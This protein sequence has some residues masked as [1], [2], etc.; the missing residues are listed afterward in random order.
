MQL[1]G[2]GRL[3]RQTALV[4]ALVAGVQ[5]MRQM[6]GLSALAKAS[7]KS[8]IRLLGPILHQLMDGENPGGDK[9]TWEARRYPA[10]SVP[11]KS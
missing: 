11:S 9:R 2:A 1:P 3:F 8:L 5:V 4:L 10:V 6:I 7:P